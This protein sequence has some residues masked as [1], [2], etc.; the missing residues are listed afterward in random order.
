ML[1]A[2][3]Q[4]G[5]GATSIRRVH[6]TLRAALDSALRRQYVAFNAALHVERPAAARPKVRPLEPAELGKLLDSL[7]SDRLGALFELIAATGLRCGEACGL[8]WADVDLGRGRLVV[9]QQLTQVAAGD[10]APCPSCSQGHRGH[11]FG[12]PKTASGEAR[13]VDLDGG[14]TGVLLAHRLAQDAERAEWGHG[15]ADHDLVFAREV[16]PLAL[17]AVTKRFGELCDAAGVRRVRVHDL[18]RGSASLMLAAG[19]DIALV[20]KR[21]GRSSVAITS[22]TY[23]HL[24][25]GVGREAAERAAAL[26]PRNRGDQPATNPA[27]SAGNKHPREEENP[28]SDLVRRQ[29][30]EPRTRWSGDGASP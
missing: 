8:R 2:A 11:T 13:I 4:S 6:G 27:G 28:R 3:R 5:L 23:P 24:L 9:R 16:A 30:L 29:G 21:L 12:P 20:S 1:R 17:D 15:H 10:E 14:T 26:I 25:E 7:S 19:V 22:D 18:R